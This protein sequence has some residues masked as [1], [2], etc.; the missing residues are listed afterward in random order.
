[1]NTTHN[2]GVIVTGHGVLNAKQLAAGSGA[3]ADSIIYGSAPGQ[4][5]TIDD[6]RVQLD[7]LLI[8]IRE[9]Q[10]SVPHEAEKAAR[11]VKEEVAKPE[12][13]KLAV[14]SVLDSLAGLVQSVGKLGG[15]VL[16]IKQLASLVLPS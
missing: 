4:A 1:M 12:P 16:A 3:R 6:L 14:T 13:S 9:N 7:E 15:A 2:E 10:Q 8:L 11:F 5:K